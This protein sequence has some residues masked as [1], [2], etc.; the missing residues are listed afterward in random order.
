[1]NVVNVY[2][3]LYYVSVITNHTVLVKPP[4]DSLPVLRAHF[5]PVTD[6]LPFLNQGNRVMAIL[7][8]V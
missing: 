6:N 7:G 1:M 3:D 5:P 2:L 8:S 4:A